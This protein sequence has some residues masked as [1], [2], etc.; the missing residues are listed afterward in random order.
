MSKLLKLF[1]ALQI[2]SV[3]F[4]G[5]ADT[6]GTSKVVP[7]SVQLELKLTSH[8]S[9]YALDRKGKT[10]EEYAASLKSGN[11]PYGP[12]VVI[13]IE[14]RNKG[15][16][17]VIAY[18]APRPQFVLKGPRAE[19]VCDVAPTQFQVAPSRRYVL[20]A[21]KS[22][23]LN[24]ISFCNPDKDE[25]SVKDTV[26]R[27]AYSEGCALRCINWT[28]PGEYTLSAVLPIGVS[29]APAQAQAFQ[30]ENYAFPKI[31][32]DIGLARLESNAV[33]LTI[34]EGSDTNYWVDALDDPDAEVRFVAAH[35]L[36]AALPLTE[37]ARLK[38]AAH[39]KD[40]D[41][42][43]RKS[44]ARALQRPA[45]MSVANPDADPA[46][47]GL[48]DALK[49]AN[50]GVRTFAVAA[51]A[52]WGRDVKTSTPALLPLLQDKDSGVR[53][54]TADALSDMYRTG[55]AGDPAPG[56]ALIGALKD[57]DEN[58]VKSS[59]VALG[60]LKTAAAVPELI[61]YCKH[62]NDA[63]SRA[64]IEA[65]GSIGTLTPAVEEALFAAL[66]LDAT[67]SAAAASLGKLKVNASSLLPALTTALKAEEN[68]FG[69]IA[70]V[71]AL[72]SCGVP[73]IP[74]LQSVLKNDPETS[75]RE[76]AAST[77]TA[78]QPR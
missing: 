8:R 66:K 47:V 4:A 5:E 13:M 64:A 48:I 73:A 12:A 20:P 74:L 36:T 1:V 56:D 55:G 44:A 40:T 38:M 29:P 21:G 26:K 19:S 45:G 62:A 71:R 34:Q 9:V 32:D 75:V 6:I 69:R 23:F 10:T 63:I 77:L 68:E 39:V 76:Y 35:T 17:E 54:A 65:I 78:I 57:T 58:V 2:A 49:D 67:R 11:C 61:T 18:G 16:K 50:A 22:I 7:P 52:S 41:A 28:E 37:P 43:V 25:P 70:I 33:K 51:L 72:G 60:R 46:V 24:V 31:P 14:L 3:L 42:R 15:D 53:L 27:L 59:I 30:K